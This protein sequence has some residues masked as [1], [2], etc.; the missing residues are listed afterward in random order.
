MSSGVMFLW[1]NKQ[2]HCALPKIIYA[3]I[4]VHISKKN[5]SDHLFWVSINLA[6]SRGWQGYRKRAPERLKCPDGLF[7]STECNLVWRGKKEPL[8]GGKKLHRL[9]QFRRRAWQSK[10]CQMCDT[11]CIW[12]WHWKEWQD[13]SLGAY[14]KCLM[15]CKIQMQVKARLMG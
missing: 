3:E 2:K 10:V 11:P 14:V 8:S 9:G 13:I 4:I 12:V 15:N 5:I 7:V 6:W 1:Q